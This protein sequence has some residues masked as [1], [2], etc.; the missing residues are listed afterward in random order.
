MPY[1]R[2]SGNP[3]V[4]NISS[5]LGSLQK[6]SSGEFVNRNFSYSYR[7]AKAAQNMFTICLSQELEQSRIAVCAVHPGQL[8]TRGGST[9]ADTNPADAA[10]RLFEWAK[11]IDIGN[12]G[13]FVQPMAGDLPW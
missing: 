2:K 11:G 6:M 12:T 4:I 5:R 8:L 3:R 10:H 13:Q 7:M 9:D 1:L